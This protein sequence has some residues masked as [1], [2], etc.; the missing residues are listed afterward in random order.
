MWPDTPRTARTARPTWHQPRPG[1]ANEA[2]TKAGPP[3]PKPPTGPAR[4]TQNRPSR[5]GPGYSRA[6]PPRGKPSPAAGATGARTGATGARTGAAGPRTGATGAR[7]GAAGPRPGAAGPRTGATGARTG[8]A[9]PRPGATGARTGAAGPRTTRPTG[10]APPSSAKARALSLAE[11][12]ERRL[13]T[14]AK[15]PTTRR[16]NNFST[17]RIKRVHAP[18]FAMVLAETFDL[19]VDAHGVDLDVYAITANG[20]RLSQVVVLCATILFDAATGGAKVWYRTADVFSK[21]TCRV[22]AASAVE[23]GQC[24]GMLRENKESSLTPAEIARV[25]DAV[26]RLAQGYTLTPALRQCSDARP[27]HWARGIELPP[28]IPA[29]RQFTVPKGDIVAPLWWDTPPPPRWT[30]APTGPPGDAV[31]GR[32]KTYAEQLARCLI[33]TAKK[34]HVSRADF[35]RAVHPDKAVHTCHQGQALTPEL[36]EWLTAAMT[37]YSVNNTWVESAWPARAATGLTDAD[38]FNAVYKNL[39][40]VPGQSSTR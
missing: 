20:V 23:I 6:S 38:C 2:R 33:N 31:I 24:C 18:D 14:L 5:A 4:T 21:A 40:N 32:V 27:P 37:H 12:A 15:V 9:G 30:A 35:L 3:P 8:A 7:T 13:D 1:E 10:R 39:V 25:E 36:I 34:A 28:V 17:W 29:G 22:V 16:P 11:R 19:W 26:N